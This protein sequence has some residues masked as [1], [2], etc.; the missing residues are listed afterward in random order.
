[1][2]SRNGQDIDALPADEPLTTKEG[3]RRFVEFDPEPPTPS[4]PAAATPLSP[5]HKAAIAELRRDYH[6]QLPLV[7]TPTIR[8]VLRTGR[9]LIQ[10]NRGQ[11]SARR[12][13]ILSGASGTGK[14]TALTQLGRTHERATRKRHLGPA[15]HN[16][17]PVVYVTVPPAATARMLAVEFARFFGLEFGSRA[18]MPDIVNAVCATAARTNVELVLVDEI[19][20]L[21]LATRSGAEVSDQLKYFAERLPATFAYAGIE[22]EAQGLFAGVRGR[23]IAGRFTLIA[24]TAFAY[25]TSDQ[26]DTWRALV[27]SLENMLELD[28]H[29]PG[30]LVGLAEYLYQRTGGMIGTLSQLIRGAAILAIDDGSEKITR[31]LLDEIPVDY[32]ATRSE[33]PRRRP[34]SGRGEASA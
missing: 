30:T 13:L 15:G 5:R 31:D 12:G 21:N 26:R 28:R 8:Q 32:A 3:W 20:N 17:I 10:L 29:K 14:T 34:K 6:G 18:N 22:V 7:N 1:M 4:E 11:V 23:Q 24:S 19:H 2:S 27:A 16:R 25:G 9:M 33:P